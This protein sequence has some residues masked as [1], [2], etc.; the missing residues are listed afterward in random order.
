MSDVIRTPQAFT[1]YLGL[2]DDASPDQVA[3]ALAPMFVPRALPEL[4]PVAAATS[5]AAITTASAAP[6]FLP[7]LAA[8]RDH[9]APEQRFLPE[10]AG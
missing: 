6:R 5:R 2:A 3:A 8:A 4:I 1:A 9:G 10:L 7:E